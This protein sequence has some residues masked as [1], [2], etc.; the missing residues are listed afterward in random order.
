[1]C[2]GRLSD[3]Q[4]NCP[5]IGYNRIALI[6]ELLS[7]RKY[8]DVLLLTMKIRIFFDIEVDV[9]SKPVRKYLNFNR[10]E[11]KLVSWFRQNLCS[12]VAVRFKIVG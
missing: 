1:M 4:V 3:K 9:G 6:F 2:V 10:F 8:L 7:I 12:L 5:P 11:G